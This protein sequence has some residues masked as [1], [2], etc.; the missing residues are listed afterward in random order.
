MV[1]SGIT[2]TVIASPFSCITGT[3]IVIA[4]LAKLGAC[5]QAARWYSHPDSVTDVLNTLNIYI[6]I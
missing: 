6:Y 1:M 2:S 5:E 4:K 3:S